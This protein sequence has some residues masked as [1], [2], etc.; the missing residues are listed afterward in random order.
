MI[1]LCMRCWLGAR[2]GLVCDPGPHVCSPRGACPVRGNL[3]RVQR[4][5]RK[6]TLLA[7]A[8]RQETLLLIKVLPAAGPRMRP[9]SNEALVFSRG[10]LHVKR[11]RG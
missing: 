7:G 11:L 9:P 2:K 1:T 10:W 8:S 5:R 4:G 3:P 6:G